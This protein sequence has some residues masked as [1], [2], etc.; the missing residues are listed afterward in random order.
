MLHACI[1]HSKTPTSQQPNWAT[2]VVFDRTVQSINY[3][4]ERKSS[5]HDTLAMVELVIK[6]IPVAYEGQYF[7][8][9]G[10]GVDVGLHGPNATSFIGKGIHFAGGNGNPPRTV[11]Y[12]KDFTKSVSNSTL[13]FVFYYTPTDIITHWNPEIS[14]YIP[15]SEVTLSLHKA[16]EWHNVMHSTINSYNWCIAHVGQGNKLYIELII[17]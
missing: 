12:K 1:I 17:E 11:A 8:L 10:G 16:G 15:H 9:V 7:T 2:P 14:R 4:Y 13:H 5:T 6:N 3:E